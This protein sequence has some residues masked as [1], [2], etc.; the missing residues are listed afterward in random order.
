[1]MKSPR[2]IYTEELDKT[3]TIL[4]LLNQIIEKLKT[5]QTTQDNINKVIPTD[6]GVQNN[7]LG[8]LH[9]TE[10]LTNQG[11]INLEGFQYDEETNTLKTLGNVIVTFEN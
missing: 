6:V 11:A 1:M 3:C 7:K 10:W 4:Q 5:I 9:D 8:L 2:K